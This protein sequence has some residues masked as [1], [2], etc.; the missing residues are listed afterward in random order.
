MQHL[1]GTQND[2][3]ELLALAE[4]LVSAME[5]LTDALKGL[6]GASPNVPRF[7]EH[8]AEYRQWLEKLRADT[9]VIN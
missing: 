2:R 1:V 8:I 5:E 6:Q 7:D 4:V 9:T 3:A